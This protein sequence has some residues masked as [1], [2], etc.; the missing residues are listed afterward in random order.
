VRPE[1]VLFQCHPGTFVVS[2]LACSNFECPCS[3]LT[4][5]LRE[6]RSRRREGRQR[7]PLSIQ[8]RVDV[9]V[10]DEVD[11]VQRPALISEIIEEFLRDFPEFERDLL[12]K[13]HQNRMHMLQRLRVAVFDSD[14]VL[15]GKMFRFRDL[16]DSPL[17]L[18][19]L[20]PL[21]EYWLEADGSYYLV[22]ELF[23]INP[24]CDCREAV[25]CFA[26]CTPLQDQ[27]RLR[28]MRNRFRVRVSLDGDCR[29]DE[30]LDIDRDSAQELLTQW[31]NDYQ[32][33]LKQLPWRYD[34]MKEIGR[35]SLA[36][37][38]PTSPPIDTRLPP[39]R[40]TDER[41][42]RNVPLR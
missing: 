20:C 2:A 40:R 31:R 37:A 42:G 15:Q 19:W 25:V 22:S 3:V 35:R 14:D 5:D 10:W 8:F 32:R 41:V 23:C 33:D 30:L 11:A 6:V 18:N 12:K 26:D 17:D 28:A 16:L 21:G 27:P 39:L 29:L 36:A 13:T 24:S 7:S 1:R 38:P 34:K 4:F 9:S